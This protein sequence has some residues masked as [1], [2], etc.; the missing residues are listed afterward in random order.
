MNSELYVVAWAIA[1][2]VSLLHALITGWLVVYHPRPI[3]TFL[4]TTPEYSTNTAEGPNNNDTLS[5]F[6]DPRA[7]V[8]GLAIQASTLVIAVVAG[9][10]AVSGGQLSLGVA[11]ITGIVAIAIRIALHLAMSF[12]ALRFRHRIR[13]VLEPFTKTFTLLASPKGS[14]RLLTVML[15]DAFPGTPNVE[16]N[17]SIQEGLDLLEESNV[18]PNQTNELMMIR[19]ILRMDTMKV[20]EIMRPRPDIVAVP[21]STS[22]KDTAKL[23]INKGYSK[24]PVYVDTLDEIKGMV[25]ARD[26][27]SALVVSPQKT[28]RPLADILH[29]TMTVPEYQTLGDLQEAFKESRTSIALVIDEHGGVVGLI[30][31]ADLMEEILGEM[32]D[33]FDTDPPEIEMNSPDE[34][35]ADAAVTIDQLNQI[36]GSQLFTPDADTL[37]GVIYRELGHI[38]RLGDA[39]TVAN[40]K[41]TV[42]SVSGRRIKRVRVEKLS[43]STPVK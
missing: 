4:A 17:V 22:L 33:E 2:G 12:I 23:M 36:M 30:T 37:S 24:L 11:I 19:S 20:K 9:V 6:L 15:G 34:A 42:E 31:V 13:P 35:S 1:G 8:V 3:N 21:A 10:Y 16:T 25:F 43:E 29:T 7:R 39:I 14:L 28:D 26:L 32:I 40:V 41:L 38:P 18:V 27:M 5:V